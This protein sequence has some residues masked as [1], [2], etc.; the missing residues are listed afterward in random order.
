MKGLNEL[1]SLV[2][3]AEHPFPDIPFGTVVATIEAYEKTAITQECAKKLT[4]VL[5]NKK[6][7]GEALKLSHEQGARIADIRSAIDTAQLTIHRKLKR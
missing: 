5:T 4:K 2:K 1:L 3:Q 6:Y 7:V